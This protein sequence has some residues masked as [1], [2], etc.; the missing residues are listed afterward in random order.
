[1]AVGGWWVYAAA[2]SDDLPGGILGVLLNNGP[3]GVVAALSL[4]AVWR[5]YR[6]ECERTDKLDAEIKELNATIQD[7]VIPALTTGNEVQ[8]ECT[9][10][11][12]AHQERE[13]A[14]WVR[15]REG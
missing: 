11:L 12:R 6:R 7:K 4:W 10:M 2:A 5:A 1:M 9:E 3:L 14:R 8:R 15:D 13:R